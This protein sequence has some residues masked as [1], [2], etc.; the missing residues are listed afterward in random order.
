MGCMTTFAESATTARTLIDRR[1]VTVRY[2][3]LP[4]SGAWDFGD[5]HQPV[6]GIGV[7]LDDGSECS[8]IW[9]SALAQFNLAVVPEN[10]D[11]VIP[12]SASAYPVWNVDGNERWLPWTSTPITDASIIQRADVADRSEL[13]PIALHLRSATND[14]WI[15]AGQ[16]DR[17]P[18]TMWWLGSDEIIVLFTAEMAGRVGVLDGPTPGTQLR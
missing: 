10:L 9:E 12:S 2:W 8:M 4:Y 15:V 3:G 1:I 18:P 6:M 14:A 13:T 11:T 7:T 5:W 16:P 17:H